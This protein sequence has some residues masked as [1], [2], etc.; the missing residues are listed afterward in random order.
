[1]N[2]D[3][4]IERAENNLQRNLDW[5][6]RHDTRIAFATGISL[7]MLG[8]LTNASAS[9]VTWTWNIYAVFGLT[10]FLLFISL[11]LVYFSQYPKTESRNASLIFFDTVSAL[12]CDDFKKKFKEMSDEDYLE[13]LLSQVHINAEI[14]SKKFNYLKVSLRL[15]AV[16]TF[17]WLFAIYLSGIYLK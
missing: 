10:A 14:L 6:G 9:I 17:P 4:K 2:L 11:T 1:M 7:A 8:I 16:A 3:N 12:K 5:V 13:D 15:L